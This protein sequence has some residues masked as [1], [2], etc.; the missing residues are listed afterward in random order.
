MMRKEFDE[1][2]RVW[3]KVRKEIEDESI[4]FKILLFV[5]KGV[6]LVLKKVFF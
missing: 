6:I 2:V 5:L 4:L 3:E 1:R